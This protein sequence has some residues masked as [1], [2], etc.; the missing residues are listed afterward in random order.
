MQALCQLD[1]LADHFLPQL[2]E[3]LAENGPPEDVKTYAQQLAQD[4][5]KNLAELDAHIQAVAEHWDL[6]RMAMVDRNTLRVAVCELVY[7]PE[8]SPAV[9]INEAIEIGRAFGTSESAAFINGI[10]DAVLKRR[11]QQE[12]PPTLADGLPHGTV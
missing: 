10:L 6:K 3:F 8:I 12:R 7:R 9:V 4:A 11:L 2:G 1:T 5:W